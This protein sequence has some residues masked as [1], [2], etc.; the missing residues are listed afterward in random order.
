[1]GKAR[2]LSKLSS[3]LNAEG[4][5]PASKGGTGTT[6][7]A[8]N[9]LQT[10]TTAQRPAN[11]TDGLIRINTT[12]SVV[13]VFYNN[14]WSSIAAVGL[15]RSSAAAAA[16]AT[17]LA[18]AGYTTNGNYWITVN[19]TPTEVYVDFTLAGGPYVLVMVTASTG[20]AYDY[21]STVW[22]NTAGGVATALDPTLDTNQVSTAF[23]Y[24][25]TTRSGLALR[26][27]STAYFHYVDHTQ[28]TARALANGTTPPS[29]VSPNGTTIAPNSIIP[30]SSPA[31][32][33]GWWNAITDSGFAAQTNGST[34]YRYGY[35]HGTPEPVQFGWCRF[36][37]SADLDSSDSRDR[38][39]GIGIK[40][41][42]G[43]PVATFTASAGRWDYNDGTTGYKNNLR[44]FLF[45]KN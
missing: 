31:R 26:N 28:G 14:S 7:G 44:G 6:T 19:G 36:G 12:L 33:L 45:V 3:A 29:A 17:A 21:D 10:G 4:A 18:Q 39:I 22:T 13:E 27:P 16:S 11:P 30:A 41:A 37:F 24:L 38:G 20:T 15:G 42:S 43:G 25:E 34:Y 40:N 9:G 2:N 8:S 1:M 5:V 32:A 35:S 23:Y